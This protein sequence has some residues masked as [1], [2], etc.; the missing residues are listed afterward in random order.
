M[1]GQMENIR[2]NGLKV[3]TELVCLQIELAVDDKSHF[4]EIC[5]LLNHH[6]I[7]I[8]FM[9]TAEHSGQT[10]GLFCIDADKLIA[11]ENLLKNDPSIKASARVFPGT[12]LLTIFPHQSSLGMVGLVLEKLGDNQ[13]PVY[14]MASSIAAITFVTEYRCLDDAAKLIAECMELPESATPVT[15]MIKIQQ[16]DSKV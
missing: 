10:Y 5:R 12:G 7:N 11:V 3:S 8:L 4:T 9:T 2:I 6:K 1:A 14:G 15:S 16:I 13:I